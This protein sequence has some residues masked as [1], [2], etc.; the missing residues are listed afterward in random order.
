MLSGLI[1]L[2]A[3]CEYFNKKTEERIPTDYSDKENIDYSENTT[4]NNSTFELEDNEVL[5]SFKGAEIKKRATEYEFVDENGKKYLVKVNHI[6]DKEDL[7]PIVPESLLK[8]S[9]AGK[10]VLNIDMVGKD[11]ILVKDIDGIVREVMEK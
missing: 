2:T 6:Q 3:S 11:Y 4:S 8:N 10:K 1:L 7:E 9:P 5:A